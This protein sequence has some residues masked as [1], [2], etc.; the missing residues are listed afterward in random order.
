MAMPIR[1]VAQPLA[2]HVLSD[3][4]LSVEALTH[5]LDLAGQI[6]RT[7]ARFAKTLSGRYLSLMAAWAIPALVVV[8]RRRILYM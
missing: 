8:A 2:R 4:D 5:L 3:L 6:K 1:K 7:P